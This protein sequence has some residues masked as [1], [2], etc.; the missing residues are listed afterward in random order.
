MTKRNLLAASIRH[1]HARF[2]KYYPRRHCAPSLI[3]SRFFPHTTN[4]LTVLNFLHF[5]IS[6]YVYTRGILGCLLGFWPLGQNPAG[7]IRCNCRMETTRH[8]VSL[9]V[10]VRRIERIGRINKLVRVIVIH[11]VQFS[12]G[13]HN[14]SDRA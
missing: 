6:L 5:E 3:K 11:E 4:L 13:E 2:L 9:K 10:S 7:A 8:V 12:D 14:M 1:H